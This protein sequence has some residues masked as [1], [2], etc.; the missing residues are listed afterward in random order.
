MFIRVLQDQVR[1]L[2]LEQVFVISHNNAFYEAPIGLICCADHGL[3]LQDPSFMSNKV[4][5]KDCT[6]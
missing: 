5:V 4:L 1:E 2:N 6:E 3:D